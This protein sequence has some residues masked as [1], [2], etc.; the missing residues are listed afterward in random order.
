MKDEL[1]REEL[2][3]VVMQLLDMGVYKI[4]F[5]G[6]EPF[7]RADLPDLIRLVAEYGRKIYIETNGTLITDQWLQ[8]FGPLISSLVVTI[9]SVD[10]EEHD[11]TRGVPGSWKRAVQTIEKA[12]AQ[13]INVSLM[14]TFHRKNRHQLDEFVDMALELGVHGVSM[15]YLL[16]RGRGADLQDDVLS[17]E[18]VYD[19]SRVWQQKREEL[20]QRG[21]TLETTSDNPLEILLE[22]QPQELEK[23]KNS[24][25]SNRICSKACVSGLTLLH[26]TPNGFVVPCSGMEGL[27]NLYQDDNNVR[28]R[29]IQEIWDDAW[30]F[31]VMRG[32]LDLDGEFSLQD[33][34][35]D[36]EYFIL[37]GGGCRATALLKYG[38]YRRADAFC[39]HEPKK[40]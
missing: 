25:N 8:E 37:C 19:F 12:V 30:I 4:K 28:K 10:P 9:G 39:W 32:R 16:P 29:S 40:K 26:I 3:Q 17:P 1:T 20:V 38:D 18:E 23:M 11:R 35:A 27:N 21:E 24:L 5:L 31:Q 7:K 14:T 6:G 36:C 22:T 13:G 34:C 15:S 33:K 2:H